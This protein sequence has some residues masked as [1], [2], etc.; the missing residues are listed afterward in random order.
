MRT[1]PLFTVVETGTPHMR[2]VAY[3]GVKFSDGSCGLIR[4]EGLRAEIITTGRQEADTMIRF[5]SEVPQIFNLINTPS[6][7]GIELRVMY[8]G[9]PRRIMLWDNDDVHLGPT[10]GSSAYGPDGVD[11]GL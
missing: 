1:K 4:R 7:Q 3:Y 8:Q 9:H 5:S 11:T 6:R 2:Q 10:P